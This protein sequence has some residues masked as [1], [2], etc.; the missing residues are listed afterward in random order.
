MNEL[1]DFGPVVRRRRI[2]RQTFGAALFLTWFCSFMR[3]LFRGPPG[4]WTQQDW[5]NATATLINSVIGVFNIT[6][7]ILVGTLVFTCAW[8]WAGQL[9]TVEPKPANARITF[10]LLGTI[11]LILYVAGLGFMTATYAC[12]SFG[13]E[14]GGANAFIALAC[15]VTALI[16]RPK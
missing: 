4:G 8:Y 9:R 14:R 5:A 10:F 6:P 11:T 12:F 15:F 16:V 2:I 13:D 1:K 3:E 7:Y